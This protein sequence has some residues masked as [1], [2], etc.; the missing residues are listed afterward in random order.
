MKKDGAILEGILSV[1]EFRIRSRSI[2][3]ERTISKVFCCDLLSLAMSKAPKGGVWVT[4]MGNVNTVAVASLTDIS[5]IVLA[6][7]MTMDD[8]ALSKAID[9]DIMVLETFLP[10]YEAACL[11]QKCIE[12]ER[13]E[14][15]L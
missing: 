3:I 9:E 11:V 15:Y 12:G 2:N 6:E 8:F 13:N 4:V 14:T 1:G 5:C 7:D 10:I